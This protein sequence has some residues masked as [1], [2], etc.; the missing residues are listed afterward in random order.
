MLDLVNTLSLLDC[1]A[2]D[3][4]DKIIKWL[5]L[6][7]NQFIGY[8]TKLRTYDYIT[9]RNKEGIWTAFKVHTDKTEG[10]RDCEIITVSF[11]NDFD[12]NNLSSSNYNDGKF[13]LG[14][15]KK[16]RFV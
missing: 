11:P 6:K 7:P 14:N 13:T 16:R 12:I 5:K 9:I 8:I 1:K 4:Y 3:H 10:F 15:F 2:Q